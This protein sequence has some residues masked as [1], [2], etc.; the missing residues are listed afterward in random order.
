MKN[1]AIG[2]ALISI[3]TLLSGCQDKNELPIQQALTEVGYVSVSTINYRLT[4]E[5]QGRTVAS[6]IAEVRPQVGGIIEQRLFVE[7][8][9][10]NKGDIL[11]KI[12]PVLYQSA[13]NEA[14]ANLNSAKA[15]LHSA[16][17]KDQRNSNL[18]KSK[19]VSQ[20]DADD[21]HA[22]YLEAKADIAKYNAVLETAH[23]NL[24]YTQVQAQLSGRIG[25]SN[26][27]PGALVTSAQSTPLATI[28]AL[29]PIYV[30]VKQ[31]SAE[32]LKL[33]QTLQRQGVT[34]GNAEVSLTLEDGSFYPLK[35]NLKMREVSVDEATG[36]VTMR[37]EFPNPQSLLLPGMF[38]RAQVT[39]A[40]DE[41]AILVPQQGIYHG[42]RG[43]AYAYIIGNDNIIEK[44]DV[45][46]DK[47]IGNQ[48]LITQ[49]LHA[50]DKLLV[51]GSN[52]VA[53]GDKV[54]AVAVTL[55]GVTV[56]QTANTSST[57]GG[58]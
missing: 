37:A 42:L 52:K 23:I 57:S 1:P 34:Q 56:P 16:Q 12:N 35:G 29:D 48:W 26:V 13:Y 18:A 19:G 2:A 24:Q 11:Y 20:Q 32:L 47:A 3:C 43:S 50:N 31:S 39:V 7:G 46:A 25:I 40:Q 36:S 21:A 10:V 53:P 17:L 44:R 5:L 33:R 49:G 9:Q 55:S 58:Q 4:S 6:S 38:V 51:E 45:I 30:D 15:T 41:N 8:S 27:T 28:M 22:S 14:L 54:K